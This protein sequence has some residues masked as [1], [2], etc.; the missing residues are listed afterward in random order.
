MEDVSQNMRNEF[1]L[2]QMNKAQKAVYYLREYGMGFFLR[3]V[4]KKLGVKENADDI[5][6]S[7]LHANSPSRKE[8][9]QQKNQTFAKKPHVC[10]VID[11][12]KKPEMQIARAVKSVREQ[13]Y[14]D[15]QVVV[16]TEKMDV[17][18]LLSHAQQE[19]EIFLFVAAEVVLRPQMLFE[20]VK[21][22]NREEEFD[23]AYVDEDCLQKGKFCRPYF[24]PD[25]DEELL[26]N[27]QYLG[28]AIAVSAAWLKQQAEVDLWGNDWYDL[29]LRLFESGAQILHIS[30]VLF[31]RASEAW[32]NGIYRDTTGSG[33]KYIEESLKRRGIAAKVCEGRV[34]G[35]Y[36]VQYTFARKPLV[37]IIIPNKDHVVELSTCINGILN[38]NSYD[39]YEIIIAENNSQEEAT[40]RY[41]EEIVEQHDRIQVVYWRKEFNYSAINNFAAENAKGELLLFLNNDTEIINRDCLEELVQCCYRE[42]IGAAGAMLYYPDNT[43][44][45]AGVVMGIGGFAAHALWS[46]SDQ[47]ERYYPYSVTMR[48]FSACTGACLLVSAEVFREVGGFE[49]KLQVALND[50]DLCMKIR[51]LGK[52]IIFNPYAKMYHYESKSRGYEDSQEK[53]ERFNREIAF[54][55]EKWKTQLEAGDPY[56]NKNQTLHRADYSVEW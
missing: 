28:G 45:H 7:W 3:K 25:K 4:A 27:F 55:Q 48:E 6:R 47:D 30:E 53:I 1:E 9:S 10:V 19:A 2:S 8:L 49:E 24:K 14:S 22:W 32:E 54:F 35:F 51:A 13:T 36:H 5:Y 29:A 16:N 33:K 18:S 56:Y 34:P 21:A 17:H 42:G 50:I 52:K 23:C 44:Q 41:Y 39:N 46:L 11:G 12:V 40:F 26:L 15:Y 38:N 43:I 37:S 20:V 31:A